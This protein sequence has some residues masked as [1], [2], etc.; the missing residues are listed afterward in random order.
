MS[1]KQREKVEDEVRFHRAQM[2]AQGDTAPDSSVFDTQTPSSSDQLHHGYNKYVN[3]L[4]SKLKDSSKK[5]LQLCLSKSI[6]R[7]SLNQFLVFLSSS[8]SYPIS[9]NTYSNEVG[10]GSP[11]GG[12]PASVTPQQTMA[13]DISA[14]Y[15]DSTTTYEPRSTIID[16]D[17][18]SGHSKFET[19]F[20][21]FKQK[22]MALH[23]SMIHATY[24]HPEEKLKI[25]KLKA[26][27][28]C[29]C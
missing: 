7:K 2:R 6:L 25:I 15:V 22:I 5:G 28:E 29:E 21:F 11:Y 19:F 27:S 10:Y 12:Y 17:F 20:S 18:I 3:Q 1:K 8:W 14:D 4:E 16:S 26:S 13:Y 9:Y 24:H 23:V